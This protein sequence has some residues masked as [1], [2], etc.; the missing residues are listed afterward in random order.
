LHGAT[1]NILLKIVDFTKGWAILFFSTKTFKNYPCAHRQW[2]HNGHCAFIHGYSRQFKLTFSAKAL[3]ET[4]FVMDFGGLKSVKD[5]LFQHFDHTLLI[6]SDDPMLV[7][8]KELE[9]LGACRLVIL[10]NVSM[11]STSLFVWQNV[12]QILLERELGRVCCHS[13]ETRE[14]DKNSGIYFD[15]PDWFDSAEGV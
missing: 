15:Y 2:R 11:E 8:F 13:V 14:N 3:T 4:H 10:Q 12:N 6:N 5:F 1:G 7:Y 9:K